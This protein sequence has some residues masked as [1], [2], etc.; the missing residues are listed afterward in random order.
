MLILAYRAQP[1]EAVA[2]SADGAAIAVGSADADSAPTRAPLA[3]CGSEGT[4]R[5]ESPK[6]RVLL[7]PYNNRCK[8]PARV[9]L[10]CPGLRA[11]PRE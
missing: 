4:N 2:A 10:R 1:P 5:Q 3:V 11:S 7:G 6:L 9:R 8:P